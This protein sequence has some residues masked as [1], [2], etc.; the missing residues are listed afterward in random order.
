MHASKLITASFDYINNSE[1]TG[2]SVKDDILNEICTICCNSLFT[3][4]SVLQTIQVLECQHM[5]HQDCYADLRKH[6]S[7]PR[8]AIQL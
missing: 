2:G 6:H 8:D 3:G 1:A 5:I 7:K 4:G